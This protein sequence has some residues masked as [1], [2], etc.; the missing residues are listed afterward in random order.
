MSIQTVIQAALD[1]DRGALIGRNGTIELEQMIAISPYRLQILETNAGIFPIA[2][3]R[4]CYEWQQQSIE[5]TK[6]A[7]VLATGWYEPLREAEEAALE[8]WQVRAIKI[9]L[10]AIEPYYVDPQEQ[11]TR[12]LEGHSVA[13]VTSFTKTAIPNYHSKMLRSQDDLPSAD[14][15]FQKAP[16][17]LR[18]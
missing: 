12:L 11:W 16:E 2:V 5:A 9:P 13:V 17:L 1:S 15:L 7:D 6:S 3:H 8:R 10:R 4:H 18:P 14:L